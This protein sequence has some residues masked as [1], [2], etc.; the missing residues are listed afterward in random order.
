V[1]PLNIWISFSKI[2][3]VEKIGDNDKV[4]DE[5]KEIQLD[6][7]EGLSKNH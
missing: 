3:R 2:E 7:R 6:V 5:F 1:N 4:A